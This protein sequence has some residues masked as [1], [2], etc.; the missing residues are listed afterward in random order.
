MKTPG[1]SAPDYAS[2][3]Q[4]AE[5]FA[6]LASGRA[7]EQQRQRWQAWLD[8]RAEHRSA[9]ARVEG[10]NRRLG[11]L[12]TEAGQHN[13]ASTLH[14]ATQAVRKRRRTLGM[15][16]TAFALLLGGKLLHGLP[17]VRHT[18]AAWRAD[19]RTGVG[20]QHAET[21]ADGSQLWLDTNSAAD[22]R[23]DAALR[24]IVLH[25][26]ALLVRTAPDPARRPLVVDT[27]HGRLLALGT[28]FSVRHDDGRTHLSVFNG[29]VEI[30][31]AAMGA[32]PQRVGAGQQA[33]YTRD[34]SDPLRPLAQPRPQWQDGLLIADEMPLADFLAELGR[35]RHGHLGCAPDVARLKVVGAYP[36]Q[37][38]DRAL[39]LL[40]T[41]L[42]LRIRRTLPWWVTLEAR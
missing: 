3:Q 9:W 10:I 6:V 19:R 29:T 16:G 12:S 31:P 17:P 32:A 14:A 7:T 35:Y 28:W 37:D 8:A 38:T 22:V 20:E 21:L 33:S 18:L 26:G 36:L 39:E 2:L 27:P 42:P 23:Y 15:L 30:Q 25:G 5:W 41:A 24:R 13:A 1:A 40:A 34:A 4:A 11:T